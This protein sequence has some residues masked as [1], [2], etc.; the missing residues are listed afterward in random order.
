MSTRPKRTR[1]AVT[2]FTYF[3]MGETDPKKKKTAVKP[4]SKSKTGHKVSGVKGKPTN[5]PTSV[6]ATKPKPAKRISEPTN[7]DNDEEVEDYKTKLAIAEEKEAEAAEKKHNANKT[8]DQLTA[9]MI[10]SVEQIVENLTNG[11]CPL[12]LIKDAWVFCAAPDD[13]GCKSGTQ[14]LVTR[15]F[16][17]NQHQST[18]D[19][20][21]F[22][23]LMGED[24]GDGFSM[25]KLV[26]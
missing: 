21:L 16:S 18:K 8:D 23:Q 3:S 26:M 19:G 7:W 13:L 1:T 25:G 15:T 17:P 24:T 14:L 2:T 11:D 5:K 22:E 4:G 12:A 6:K 20:Q 10:S 9:N